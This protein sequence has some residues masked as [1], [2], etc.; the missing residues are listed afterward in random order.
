MINIL[1]IGNSFS[2]D[3]TH[4]LNQIAKEDC[5]E[6]KVVNLYIGGCSLERHWS[7]VQSGA[8][9]YLYELN[10]KSTEKYISIQEALKEERWD[11]IV[12]QQASHDSGW[13]DTYEPFLENLTRYIRKQAPWAE[14]LLQETWAYEI[15]STHDK[16]P[17]YHNSQQEMYE[18]LRKAY[19]AAAQRHSLRLI[20]CGDII[21]KL[22]RIPPFVYEE[23]GISLC[24][25]GFHMSY[26][27]GRYALA[28]AWYKTITG[29]SVAQNNYIPKTSFETD[30][31]AD[32]EALL[33]IKDIIE[34]TCQNR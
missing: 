31:K 27:Y 5:V 22:R 15:D 17:R 19:N 7:N 1:A 21:Q 18:R 24:R 16:F 34:K 32:Q 6:T 9:D 14:I 8:E 13:T 30:K 23:G 11:Y 33:V 28:A 26:I 20:P 2:Q 4:Y 29:N 3:A 25:D 12:T 10:G